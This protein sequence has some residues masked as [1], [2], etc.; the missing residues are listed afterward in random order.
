VVE[1]GGSGEPVDDDDDA[2]LAELRKAMADE[3]P[4]GP[5]DGGVGDPTPG[6]LDDDRRGWRFGKRR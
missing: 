1:L 3:E 6:F 2:F 5:R 4:L